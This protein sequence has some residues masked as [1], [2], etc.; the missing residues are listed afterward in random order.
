MV[1]AMIRVGTELR[2][3]DEGV[4]ESGEASRLM[5]EK[6][7]PAI[8][9]EE[10]QVPSRTERLIFSSAVLGVNNVA[11]RSSVEDLVATLSEVGCQ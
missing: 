6:F 2:D 3:D 11:F 7:R 8:N 10:P 1:A 5:Q 9:A 4:G